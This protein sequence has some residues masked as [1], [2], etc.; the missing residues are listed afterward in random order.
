MPKLSEAPSIS[1]KHYNQD[2]RDLLYS[3]AAARKA[4]SYRTIRQ[5][6]VKRLVKMGYY[7]PIDICNAT[8]MIL[9]KH[10]RTQKI[11]RK[12]TTNE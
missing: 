5:Q 10:R 3:K 12:R 9:L 7:Q 1:L 2:S 4:Y 8:P 11:T 6:T